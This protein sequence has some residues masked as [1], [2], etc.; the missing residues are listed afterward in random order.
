M[1]ADWAAIGVKANLLLKEMAVYNDLGYSKTYP[2]AIVGTGGNQ[3]ENAH[4][5]LVWTDNYGNWS[6]Y[7]D[8]WFDEQSAITVSTADVAARN[9]LHIEL[10]HYIMEKSPRIILPAPNFYVF[11]QPWLK[12][13]EGANEAGVYHHFRPFTY[14]WLDKDK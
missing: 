10:S 5:D 2:G 1:A 14:V 4:L 6:K 9:K 13:W 3:E 7:T 8:A 12:G 11:W